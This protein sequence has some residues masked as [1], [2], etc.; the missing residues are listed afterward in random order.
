[1]ITTR[2][3]TLECDE[4]DFDAIQSAMSIVQRSAQ[5]T[6]WPEPL[7]GSGDSNVAA[8]ALAEVCRGYIEML[9]FPNP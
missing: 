6:G 2:T 8:L 3:I 9:R 1:M 4:L 7:P 5:L